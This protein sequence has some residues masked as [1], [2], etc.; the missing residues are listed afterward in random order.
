M[1]EILFKAKRVD[2]GEW[3]EY[4]ECSTYG[5]NANGEICSFDYKHTGNTQ[6][7]VQHKDKDGYLYVF[8]KINGKREHIETKDL[9]VC[10]RSMDISEKKIKEIINQITLAVKRWPYYA[11][12]AKLK[13]AH[14]NEI[15]NCHNC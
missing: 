7:L 10:G 15:K 9:I 8:M 2:N 14:M 11:E 5:A 4:P 1:R 3:V 13:E 6:K 12:I